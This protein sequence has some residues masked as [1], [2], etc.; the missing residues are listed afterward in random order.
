MRSGKGVK[1]SCIHNTATICLLRN[2]YGYRQLQTFLQGIVFSNWWNWKTDAVL[3][4]DFTGSRKNEKLKGVFCDPQPHPPYLK[5][6]K[7]KKKKVKIFI[8]GETLMLHNIC[9]YFFLSY[10]YSWWNNRDSCTNQLLTFSIPT[11]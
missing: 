8:L 10:P 1:W 2:F 7:E 4:S 11:L 9:V 6:R 5:K 3:C